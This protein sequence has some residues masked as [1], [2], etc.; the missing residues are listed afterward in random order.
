MVSLEGAKIKCSLEM[1]K[2]VTISKISALVQKYEK[3]FHSIGRILNDESDFSFSL[4]YF[5][6]VDCIVEL[7]V[8]VFMIVIF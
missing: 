2:R 1:W 6:L 3:N 5:F 7:C 4:S 8:S